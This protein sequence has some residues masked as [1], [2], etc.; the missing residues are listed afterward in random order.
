MG[1]V[2]GAKS[3]DAAA[4]ESSVGVSASVG[5]G[6]IGAECAAAAFVAAKRSSPALRGDGGLA[7][8]GAVAEGGRAAGL[9]GSGA[10]GYPPPLQDARRELDAVSCSAAPLLL[11]LCTPSIVILRVHGRAQRGNETRLIAMQASASGTLGS[12]CGV[13]K[14]EC[15]IMHGGDDDNEWGRNDGGKEDGGGTCMHVRA[16]CH[17]YAQK[18]R[19]M[20]MRRWW[21]VRHTLCALVCAKNM[22][23][24]VCVCASP[25]AVSIPPP[26]PHAHIAPRTHANKHKL[27]PAHTRASAKGRKR[28]AMQKAKRARMQSHATTHHARTGKTPTLALVYHSH[29]STAY[30]NFCPSVIQSSYYDYQ[31]PLALD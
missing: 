16:M 10:V 8:A 2:D 11:M 27:M 17:V 3:T 1:S 30:A 25:A 5:S 4:G 31:A 21:R 14:G 18:D 29:L 15:V 12:T 20:H 9:G 22:C 23:V 24:C 19:N 28:T 6:T 7:V 26:S 13:A